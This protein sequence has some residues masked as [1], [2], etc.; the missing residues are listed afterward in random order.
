MPSFI[1]SAYQGPENKVGGKIVAES[2]SMAAE[3]LL[4]RG[5]QPIDIR[6]PD[7]RRSLWSRLSFRRHLNCQDRADL[8]RQLGDLVISGMPMLDALDLLEH[9]SQSPR[10]QVTLRALH[11][12][13]RDG[14]SLGEAMEL[15]P[16]DFGQVQVSLIKAGEGAGL[17]T[18]VL[19]QS[20][21]LDEREHHLRSRVQT[22]LMYPT[23]TAVVGLLT[24]LVIL[25]F[26]IPRLSSIFEEMG[27]ALPAITRLLLALSDT[28]RWIWGNG[29]L[30]LL[31]IFLC[32]K[33][34]PRSQWWRDFNDRLLLR[35]PKV[36][37]LILTMQIARFT[38]ILSSLLKSGVAMVPALLV[39]ANTLDNRAVQRRIRSA[40]SRVSEG[41]R[42]GNALE[43][44]GAL[45]SVVN[46]MIAVGETT[47]NLAS[48]LERISA[49]NSR[50]ADRMVKITVG[51]IEPCLIIIMGVFVAFIVAAVILPIF[52]V[53]LTL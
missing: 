27:Q 11:G 16:K 1:Y 13:V 52:Q 38:S 26:V 7:V 43:K 3:I 24:V 12:S 25:N 30:F 22:A 6:T 46:S 49:S 23:I 20:A 29:L 50:K 33:L 32:V 45:S 47:G 35:L 17:L 8:A 5:L 18:T 21:E 37:N 9:Q 15:L 42:L 4:Q 34:V 40:A 44:E 31:V 10:Q 14:S 48:T 39:T 19:A 51:L 36:G 53:N 41:E 2:E 28:A